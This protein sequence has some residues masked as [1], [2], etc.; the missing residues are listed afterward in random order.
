MTV[1]PYSPLLPAKYTAPDAGARTAVPRFALMSRPWWNSCSPVQGDVRMPNRELS[2][3][4]TGQRRGNDR[5]MGRVLSMK[6]PRARRLCPLSPTLLDR[7][8]R[9]CGR[10]G[11][12]LAKTS[13]S[14]AIA[15][16]MP[17]PLALLPAL[18]AGRLDLGPLQREVVPPRSGE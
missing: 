4:R 6:R 3:P 2:G 14:T 13:G 10:A 18:D 5:S 11:V 12:S 1:F 15:P 16:P 8:A 17:V 7:S 9:A